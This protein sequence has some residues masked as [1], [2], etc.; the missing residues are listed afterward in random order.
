VAERVPTGT[1]ARPLR[2]VVIGNSCVFLTV[3]AAH[4]VDDDPYPGWLRELLHQRGVEATVA[5]HSQWHTTITEALPRFE[6]WVRDELPDV[7][8]ANFGI[9]DAQA[10]VL[11]T[12]LLRN[13]MT[14]LPGNGALAHR[15]R[16]RVVP[17]LRPRV[18]GWQRYWA[19]RVGPR[20]SRV[21]PS[22]FERAMA[23]L[24]QLCARQCNAHV[25]VLDIDPA[26]D[27]LLSWMPGLQERID[28]YNGILDRVV[29]REQVGR[30]TLLRT[31]EVV[32]ADPERLLPDGIH[33][34]AEG[35]RLVA[36]RIV[37][38]IVR[39]GPQLGLR[40]LERHDHA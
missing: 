22:V 36:E 23:R 3:P 15:Y 34:S 35:H 4:D 12:W 21:R 11:P 1:P 28:R 20:W 8:I 6:S 39:L 38:E 2:I 5:V 25:V 24:L 16:R 10:R 26:N 9:V 27:V 40:Q 14:W 37:D 19:G 31:S 29:Q 18:R 13:T 30:A 17:L 7:V 33:R 32:T